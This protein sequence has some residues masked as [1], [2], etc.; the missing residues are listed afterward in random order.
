MEFITIDVLKI[1]Q[2]HSPSQY[3]ITLPMTPIINSYLNKHPISWELVHHRLLNPSKR[4]MKEI[5]HNQT[6]NGLSKTC[7]N[8]I[9][10]APCTIC[11]TTKNENF[12]QSKDSWHQRLSTRITYSHGLCLLQ[13]TFHP[14][15]PLHSHFCLC[16]DKNAIGITYFIHTRYCPHHQ[17][18]P[19]NI[20]E[21]TTPM[22]TCNSWWIW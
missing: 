20:E 22:Q 15:I 18:H 16:K 8:K 2:Q 13:C 7:S 9:N 3:I 21:W 11:Y 14:W 12:P 6:L 17:I 5:C 10:Q 19:N 1:K 4:F